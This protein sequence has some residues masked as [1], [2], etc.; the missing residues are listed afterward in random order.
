MTAQQDDRNFVLLAWGAFI[1]YAVV[2]SFLCLAAVQ[3]PNLTDSEQ[4][5]WCAVAVGWGPI[6]LLMALLVFG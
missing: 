2:A 6:L 1:A 5:L 3:N 4:W